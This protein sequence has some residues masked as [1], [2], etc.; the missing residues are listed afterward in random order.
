MSRHTQQTTTTQQKLSNFLLPEDP[1]PTMPQVFVEFCRES[2]QGLR[3]SQLSTLPAFCP[4]SG[5]TQFDG[6]DGAVMNISRPDDH[7]EMFQSIPTERPVVAIDTS[8]IKLGE[9]DYGILCALRGAVVTLE[10]KSYGYTR[11]GP[12]IFS[13]GYDSPVAS[14]CLKT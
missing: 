7:V 14:R 4:E 6:A 10:S 3:G 1:T 11:Y 12:F 2:M 5:T 9:L 13:L 8:T